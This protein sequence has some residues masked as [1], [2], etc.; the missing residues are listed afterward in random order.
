MTSPSRLQV[1]Y[2]LTSSAK[3]YAVYLASVGGD[4]LATNDISLIVLGTRRAA[5]QYAARVSGTIGCDLV[6]E[7]KLL[8]DRIGPA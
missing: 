3:G 1:R 8:R 7:D 2:G 4:G 5:A 6:D